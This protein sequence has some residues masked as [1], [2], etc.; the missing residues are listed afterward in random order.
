MREFNF[1]PSDQCTIVTR[2]RSN[3]VYVRLLSEIHYKYIKDVIHERSTEL[4]WQAWLLVDDQNQNKQNNEGGNMKKKVIAKSVFVVPPFNP[5]KMPNCG[6]GFTSDNTGRC[7][8]VFQVDPNNQLQ[9]LLS[10]LQSHLESKPTTS[11][12]PE[13]FIIGLPESDSANDDTSAALVLTQNPKSDEMNM[14]NMVASSG[15]ANLPKVKLEN[16]NSEEVTETTTSTPTTTII[17]ETETTT[18]SIITTEPVSL[19][20][21]NFGGKKNATDKETVTESNEGGTGTVPITFVADDHRQAIFFKLPTTHQSEQ[22]N[23]DF[24]LSSRIRF[25]DDTFSND[26]PSTQDSTNLD[27]VNSPKITFKHATDTSSDLLT[28]ENVRHTTNVVRFPDDHENIPQNSHLQKPPHEHHNP[29]N[30]RNRDKDFWHLKPAWE[31]SEGRKSFL[32]KLSNLLLAARKQKVS[33]EL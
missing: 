16:K 24:T 13:K 14:N 5:E 11:T 23:S 1:T 18:E 26:E 8:E 29:F 6:E 9:F 10:K 28:S 31:E 15:N 19:T 20:V 4:T 12:G 25:K 3:R 22:T 27:Y 30:H 2:R 17:T 7:L 32:V 21:L 33:L